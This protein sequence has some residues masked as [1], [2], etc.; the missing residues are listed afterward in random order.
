[1]RTHQLAPSVRPSVE[2][3]EDRRVPAVIASKHGRELTIKGDQAA[4]TISIVA[5]ANG[6]LVVTAG[7]LTRTFRKIQEINVN[8]KGG[9]DTLTVNLAAAAPIGRTY[10]LDVKGGA[11]DDSVMVML[12]AFGGSKSREIDVNL[13]GGSN[14]LTILADGILADAELDIE[15]FGKNGGFDDVL[16]DLGDLNTEA[17]LEVSGDLGHG[18]NRFDVI[19]GAILADAEFSYDYEGGNALD[20]VIAEMG[21]VSADASVDIDID[22]DDGDDLITVIIG[23]VD[24]DADIEINVD[25]GDGFDSGF[26]SAG[27]G[28]ENIDLDVDDVEVIAPVPP[29]AP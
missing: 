13:G 11:G 9:A 8:L 12:G 21:D 16:M 2:V 22:T 24:G 18:D 1:M 27:P 7:T 17:S 25:G 10:D 20:N 4:N 23:A 3:L 19:V 28:A 15:V 29:P 14:D 6:D 26:G 5:Q